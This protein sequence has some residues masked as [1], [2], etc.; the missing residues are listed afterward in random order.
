MRLENMSVTRIELNS[1]FSAGVAWKGVPLTRLEIQTLLLFSERRTNKETAS[2]L[3]V[4]RTVINI[5]S[6]KLREKLGFKYRE[7]MIRAFKKDMNDIKK[8][9]PEDIAQEMGL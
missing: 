2:I 9:I 3:G 6:M 4:G 8:N 7:Q 5:R 1:R